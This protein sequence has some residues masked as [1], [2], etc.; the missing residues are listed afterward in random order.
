MLCQVET[1]RIRVFFMSLALLEPVNVVQ[2]S[3]FDSYALMD[4]FI[5][6]IDAKLNSKSTYRRQIKPFIEWMTGNYSFDNL[7]SLYQPDIYLYKDALVRAGKSAYIISGYLTAVRKFFEWL[8]S[9]KIFPNTAKSVKGLKKP[10][11]FRKECLTTDQIKSALAVFDT[12]TQDGLRDYALF[13]LLMRT[14]LRTVEASR[15]TLGDLRRESGEAI[16]LVQGKG[17]NSKDDFVLLVDETLRPL[18]KYLASRG[19]LSENDPLFCSTSNRT[20]GEPLKEHIISGI[21][22]VWCRT[23][24]NHL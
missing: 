4:R 5:A 19:P 24:R 8:E 13:N 6:S 1:N 12:N 20:R 18:R 3:I 15:A 23:L 14:G 21:I 17:R 16:L 9:Q 22:K 10:K 2:E 11:G 7:R